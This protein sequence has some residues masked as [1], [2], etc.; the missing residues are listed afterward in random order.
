MT[1]YRYFTFGDAVVG[2]LADSIHDQVNNR[3][4]MLNLGSSELP[5]FGNTV[6]EALE[7]VK[8]SAI[9]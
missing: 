1:K 4:D 6:L 9:T 7:T 2:V 5:Q 3:H 8:P